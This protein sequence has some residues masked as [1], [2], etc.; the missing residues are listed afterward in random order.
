MNRL[1]ATLL[2]D[3]TLNGVTAIAAGNAHTVV[4]VPSTIRPPSV[5]RSW[6]A[7]GAGQLGSGTLIG[8][9]VPGT[10]PNL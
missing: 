1:F 2:T 3:T 7:N 4:V 6:G 10:V 8:R 5:A 9:L